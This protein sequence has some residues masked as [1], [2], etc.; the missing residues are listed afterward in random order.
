MATYVLPL[1]SFNAFNYKLSKAA[2]WNLNDNKGC[3]DTS[4]NNFFSLRKKELVHSIK[5][6]SI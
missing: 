3:R 2:D 1:I 5:I 4:I 6:K